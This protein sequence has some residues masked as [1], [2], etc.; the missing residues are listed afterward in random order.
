MLYAAIQQFLEKGYERTTTA[1]IAKAAGMSP[2]SFFAAFESK[3]ALLL[4]L[5]EEM[6]KSQFFHSEALLP[7]KGD[8][9]FLYSIR[10]ISAASHNRD[11]RSLAGALCRSLYAAD[12]RRIHQREYCE[13]AAAAFR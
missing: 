7:D 5:V 9:V 4:R 6:F 3:E 13:K 8:P 1:A 2:S 12:H 10:D 11:I